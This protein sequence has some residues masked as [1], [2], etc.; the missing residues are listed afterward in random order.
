MNRRSFI[1]GSLVAAGC[2][3]GYGHCQTLQQGCIISDDQ[4]VELMGRNA[5][6]KMFS[7]SI[8]DDEVQ[9]GSGNKLFDRALAHALANSSS[10]FSVLPGFGFFD[11]QTSPNAFASPSKRLGRADGSVVFGLTLFHQLMNRPES[12][13]VCVMAVCA[14]EFGHIAQNKYGAGTRLIGASGRTKRLELH[15]D[16]LAGYFAGTRRLENRDFPAAVFA[17]TMHSLGDTSFGRQ[18]HH[19]TPEE[20]ANALVRG[21]DAA[22]RQHLE[23]KVAFEA[24]VQYVLQISE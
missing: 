2:G 19:G 15:A 22:Y 3:C 4:I 6:S 16:Y 9:N 10:C 14:H 17:A 18:D 11:D 13:E 1:C 21:H 20:R 12:P 23:F 8:D 5:S 7:F 24:G